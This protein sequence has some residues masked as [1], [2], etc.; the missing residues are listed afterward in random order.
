MIP[1]V[2]YFSRYRN[3]QFSF[4]VFTQH[5]SKSL[6]H[7]V[8]KIALFLTLPTFSLPSLDSPNNDPGRKSES[9]KRQ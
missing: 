8:Q 2:T 7:K 5:G 3:V 6:D 4:L 1:S 9:I